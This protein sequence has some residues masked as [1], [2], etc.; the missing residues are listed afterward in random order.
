MFSSTE[1][2]Y[3]M[4]RLRAMCT[5]RAGDGNDVYMEI[6]ARLRK[7]GS[8][9]GWLRLGSRPRKPKED[10]LLMRTALRI[11]SR[12]RVF[13]FGVFWCERIRVFLKERLNI[14]PIVRET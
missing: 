1:M 5:A 9:L 11:L 6:A 8:A 12:F 4:N 3:S 10:G 7:T 14:F 2:W 13:R